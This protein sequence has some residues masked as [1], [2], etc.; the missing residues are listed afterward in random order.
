[1]KQDQT[2]P[3]LPRAVWG[4]VCWV[5]ALARPAQPTLFSQ[6]ERR[7]LER[8]M[9][10][11]EEEMKVRPPRLSCEHSAPLAWS[12][13]PLV[14]GTLGAELGER[15]RWPHTARGPGCHSLPTPAPAR[16]PGL[17]RPATGQA[18]ATHWAPALGVSLRCSASLEL[19]PGARFR[20]RCSLPAPWC[21]R[22]AG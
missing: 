11:M 12:S 21:S 18:A 16:E 4:A 20:A 19:R 6:Q 22:C 2:A 3:V 1:M 5:A 14:W 13:T 8:K 15:A 10:E 9:S 7:A 17:S